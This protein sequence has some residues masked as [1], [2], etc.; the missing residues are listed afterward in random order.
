MPAH[1]FPDEDWAVLAHVFPDED[2]AEPALL[3]WEG[4]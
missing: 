3:F 2:W 4:D 1:V